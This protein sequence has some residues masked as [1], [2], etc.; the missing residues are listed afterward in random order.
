ML[1]NFIISFIAS[2]FTFFI[3]YGL[4]TWYFS[5]SDHPLFR[6]YEQIKYEKDI[7]QVRTKMEAHWLTLRT[8]RDLPERGNVPASITMGQKFRF[9]KL[10]IEVTTDPF[11]CMPNK[12]C[13]VKQVE[14]LV[15][16]TD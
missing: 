14:Y 16:I 10:F 12:P 9:L 13:Q 15:R 5:Y 2:F 3:V 4:D 7:N 8:D 6:L 11:D 1:K